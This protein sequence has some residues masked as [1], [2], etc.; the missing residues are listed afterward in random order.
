MERYINTQ[1]GLLRP[2]LSGLGILFLAIAYFSGNLEFMLPALFLY[3]LSFIFGQLTTEDKGDHLLLCFG[4][5]PLI[6]RKIRYVDI[7]SA[8]LF[9]GGLFKD[10]WGIH[11]TSKGWAWNVGGSTRVRLVLKR[12]A[13]II[14][15]DDD[16]GLLEHIKSKM[17]PTG[18][19]EVAP[20]L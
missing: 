1:R 16:E 11:W 10:G 17:A 19:P 8:E 3:L 14:G 4:P 12:G 9:Q 15:S 2:I 7:V 20:G 13:I 18:K 6:R 5:L